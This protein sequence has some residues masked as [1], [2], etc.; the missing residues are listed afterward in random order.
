MMNESSLLE[1]FYY[2][3][4]FPTESIQSKDPTFASTC[5]EADEV[6]QALCKRLNDDE[7]DML[8]HL[9]ALNSDIDCMESCATFTCGF[10]FG[11]LLMLE[12][13]HGKDALFS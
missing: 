7:Q 13:L 3:N 9:L 10:R 2:G 4:L 5:D 11:A 12:I 6:Y 1:Q 8:D